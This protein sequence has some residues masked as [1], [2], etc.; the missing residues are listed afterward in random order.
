MPIDLRSDTVTQPTAAMKAAMWEAPLG[1]DVF[2]EDPSLNALEQ[3]AAKLFGHESALFCPSGTMTNQI[4]IRVHTQPG[5]EVLCDELSHI[6]HYEG[7]GIAVNSLASVR[8]LKGDRGR[9]TVD[10]IAA[11]INPDDIHFPV[12]SLVSLENTCNK[13]GGCCYDWKTVEAIAD[14]CRSRQLGLHLDGAR[15]FNAL[16]ATDTAPATVGP[17]FDTIAGAEIGRAHV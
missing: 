11:N 14:F 10:D 5:Q 6:Y 17:W 12:S 15:L 8:L 2:E 13:G 3:K 9:I 7:G 4:A 1:D 16:V